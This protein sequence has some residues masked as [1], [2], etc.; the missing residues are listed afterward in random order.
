MAGVAV[1]IGPGADL[2]G[3]HGELLGE[4]AFPGAPLCYAVNGLV[5][6]QLPNHS[7]EVIGA[8]CLLSATIVA[9]PLS[10]ALTGPGRWRRRT[11]RW[12]R[13]SCW[14]SSIRPAAICCCSGW[15]CGPAPGSP[16]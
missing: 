11:C 4:I 12:P 7:G 2:M 13:S 1:L 8:G 6:R 16:R 3:G 10:L 5:A 15:W 9:V 14:V